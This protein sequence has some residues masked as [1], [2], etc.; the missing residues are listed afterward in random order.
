MTW[1]SGI[2]AAWLVCPSLSAFQ[3]GDTPILLSFGSSCFVQGFLAL[4]AVSSLSGPDGAATPA[5]Q[6][7]V[8]GALACAR[9][10]I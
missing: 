1:G 5:N 3:R 10:I 4:K 2:I 9:Y 8:K 7:R 6:L